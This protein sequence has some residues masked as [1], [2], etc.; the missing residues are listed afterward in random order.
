MRGIFTIALAIAFCAANVGYAVEAVWIGPQT[1]DWNDPANWSTG[2]VPSGSATA[3]RIDDNPARD[4]RVELS[5]TGSIRMLTIDADDTLAVLMASTLSLSNNF[6]TAQ[7]NG[8]LRVEG[9]QFIA[10][11][12][13]A[14]GHGG[15]LRLTGGPSSITSGFAFINDGIIGGTGFFAATGGIFNRSDIRADVSSQSLTV[16]LRNQAILENQGRLMA[17]DGGLLQI[18][19]TTSSSNRIVGGR[20]EA[21]SG[22][23][24]IF[25]SSS[26]SNRITI[27]K[28]ILALV[29]DE[30]AETPAPQFE[31]NN[32][33]VLKDVTLEGDFSI[34]GATLEGRLT[35]LG[36]ITFA[37]GFGDTP[38]TGIAGEVMLTGGGSMRIV[39]TGPPS[40]RAFDGGGR[41]I[42]VDNLI[43]GVGWIGESGNLAFTNRGILDADQPFVGSELRL[44]A[45]ST[46]T[47]VNAGTMRASNGGRLRIGSI[48]GIG[49]L[50]NF[51]GDDAGEIVIGENSSIQLFEMTVVGGALRAEGD[52]PLPSTGNLIVSN[53]VTLE[54]VALDGHLQTP[55]TATLR[56]KGHIDNQGVLTSRL[57]MA[58]PV[59]FTGGGEVIAQTLTLTSGQKFTNEDHTIILTG[60]NTWAS[61]STLPFTNRGTIRTRQN[62]TVSGG[63]QLTNSGRLES[64]LGRLDLS[65]ITVLNSEKGV[66]GVIHAGMGGR[67]TLG[68]V[69]GGVLSTEGNGVIVGGNAV[70]NVHNIGALEVPGTAGLSGNVIN[71][72]IIKGGLNSGLLNLTG[73]GRVETTYANL[74]GVVSNGPEH[75]ILADGFMRSIGFFVNQGNFIVKSEDTLRMEMISFQNAGLVHVPA[76]SQLDMDIDPGRVENQGTMRIEGPTT[77]VAGGL[78]NF[79]GGV[80]EVNAN[81]TLNENTQ[82]INRSGGLVTGGGLL[83][84]DINSGP[85]LI[86]EGTVAPGDGIKTLRL[87][88]DFQQRANGRLDIDIHAGTQLASDTLAI[89][90]SATLDGALRV[91]LGEGP[92]PVLNDSFTILTA[93]QGIAG[94]FSQLVLPELNDDHFWHVQYGAGDVRLTV[95]MMIP[96]DYNLDGVVATADYISWRNSL[97][98]SGTGLAADG[99]NDGHIDAADHDLWRANFGRS[100]ATVP[101]AASAAGEAPVP[102]PIAML[103]ASIA[104]V[105]ASLIFYRAGH[106]TLRRTRPWTSL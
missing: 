59:E 1:G 49:R 76:D 47:H 42:N 2:V 73:T 27:E 24:V 53:N 50:E 19:A 37:P 54:D 65:E 46:L 92:Q 21:H 22:S 77:I 51:E 75:T 38:H 74:G 31:F 5:G 91:M 7:I 44:E 90:G 35:N 78:H 86:N 70:V 88:R 11:T 48:S 41:L 103:S 94:V 58:G 26:F 6:S 60:A 93:T 28:A 89:D 97:G 9:G 3:V 34:K 98:K 8:D 66:A 18:R 61:S 64:E 36:E 10:N 101:I 12:T 99:N 84:G 81:V 25:N 56:L 100:V 23:K 16:E 63:I 68:R 96:G 106:R 79:T 33:A 29:D 83:Y 14:I 102:E 39:S 95:A 32:R 55:S 57:H 85:L 72:G 43:H 82:L 71:D 30:I 20:I 45:N 13:I 15:E 4:T 40:P 52:A 104:F 67:I 87:G 69:E 80:I 105:A 62:L 17:T